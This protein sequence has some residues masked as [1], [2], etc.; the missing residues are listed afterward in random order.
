MVEPAHKIEAW[1]DGAFDA[2]G[3]AG[4]GYIIAQDNHVVFTGSGYVGSGPGVDSMAAE[5]SACIAVMRYFLANKIERAKVRGDCRSVIDAL[6]NLPSVPLHHREMASQLAVLQG[7]LPGVK[8]KW[9]PRSYN[10]QADTL[11]SAALRNFVSMEKWGDLNNT[12]KRPNPSKKQKPAPGIRRK[13]RR[14]LA[15]LII[16]LS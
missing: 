16:C 2:E 9:I 14:V 8:L 6:A 3:R 5:Y 15:R 10:G 13:A 12:R 4:Y 7:R 1:F 11:A